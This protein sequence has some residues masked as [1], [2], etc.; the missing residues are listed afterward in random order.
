MKSDLVWLPVILVAAAIAALTANPGLGILSVA[1]LGGGLLLLRKVAFP[2]VLVFVFAYQWLQAST[3]LFEANLAGTPL[4][5]YVDFV[6]DVERAT[7]LSLMGLMALALGMW[8]ALRKPA[9][10]RRPP[11]VILVQDRPATFWL[12]CYLVASVIALVCLTLSGPLG[13]LRQPLLAM[14]G[15]KWA[16]FLLFTQAAFRKKGRTRM[17]WIGAFLLE[18][19]LGTVGFFSDF[20]LVLFFTVFGVM[21]AGLR[22]STGRMLGLIGVGLLSLVMAMGWTAIKTEQRRFLSGGEKTQASTAGTAEALENLVDLASGL[23]GAAMEEAARTLARRVAYVEFFGRVIDMVPST[24]PY[25]RGEIWLDAVTRPLMPR[26]LFPNKSEIDDTERSIYYAG[27]PVGPFYAAT[28]ISLGYMAESYIDFGPWFMV[29]PIFA[30]GWM[31]ARFYRWCMN[32]SRAG[33]DIGMALASAVL[34]QAGYLEFS[35]TKMFGGLIV[36]MLCVWLV[37]RFVIP[38]VLPRRPGPGRALVVAPGRG[39]RP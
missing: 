8:Q 5:T 38:R 3:K 1:V 14:A 26:L 29:F 6:G 20:K 23:D 30:L 4:N 28:S 34:I 11:A 32:H 25:E 17:I 24:I 21:S 9:V 37:A 13:G 36:G 19:A 15:L 35:I 10:L 12:W 18:I 7:A 31:L 2:P 39:G 27:L 16:F 33:G 22:M